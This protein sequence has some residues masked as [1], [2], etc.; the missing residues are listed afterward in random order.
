MKESKEF[1]IQRDKQ[2]VEAYQSVKSQ[3]QIARQDKSL[4]KEE[5]I[6]KE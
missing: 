4:T 5:I 3:E 1:D 6:K 2:D